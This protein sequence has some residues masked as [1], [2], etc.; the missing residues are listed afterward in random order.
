MAQ[1]MGPT[2]SVAEILRTLSVILGTVASF[3]VLM[4]NFYKVIQGNNEKVPSFTMRPEET[5]NQI[6]LYY[7]S[8]MM[9]L[10]VQQHLKDCIFHGVHMYICDSVWYLYSS[11]GTSYSQLMVA[12]CKMESENKEI[13]DKMRARAMVATD[14]G[15]GMAELGQQIAKLMATLTKAGLGKAPLMHQVP[16]GR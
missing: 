2:A 4:Q 14:S 16:P 9:D 13:W 5:L 11:P 1:Y 3:D 6:R 7:P 8:R 15:E 10:E 12:T